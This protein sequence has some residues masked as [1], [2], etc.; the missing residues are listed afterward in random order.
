MIRHA[1]ILAFLPAVAPAAVDYT[2]Q[3]KPMLQTACVKCHGAGSQKGK[4]RV[5]TAAAAVSGGKHGAAII[6]GDSA[7]S[8]LVQA[9]DGT[10]G[11]VSKMPYKRPPLDSAQVALIRQWID[12]GAKAPADEKPSDDRHW[13]FVAPLRSTEKGAGID[14]FVR[15]RLAKEGIRP[16]PEAAPETLLRRLYLDL[17]GLPPTPEEVTAFVS[18]LKTVAASLEG[19]SGITSVY[20]RW[21]DK[22]L[23]SPHYGERWGRWWLDQ[24]RYADSNGYSIDAPRIIWPYRDWVIKALNKDLPFD[25]FT[26]EQ[27]A[28][29]LLPAATVDQKVATGFHRNTPVNGEGGIDPEQFRVESVIDRVNTTGTVWL[30]LTIGCCQCH[31][32]KFDPIPQREY[33][34]MFAFFNGTEQDGHGGTRTSTLTLPPV[35][36]EGALKL[37]IND[38]RFEFDRFFRD[39]P[40]Q[41]GD[42]EAALTPEQK[43]KLPKQ[44]IKALATPARKRTIDQQRVVFAALVKDDKKFNELESTMKKR[45]AGLSPP[46]TTLVT[47]ELPKPRETRLLIKGD[48][49]RPDAVVQRGVL[50]A[51]QPMAGVEN[52]SRL[53]LARWIVSPKNPLTARVIMNRVWQQYFGRG[54]VETENDFGTMGA[55]PTHPELL[56]WLATE[57]MAQKWSLKA[58]HR[59]IVMSQTY[60]QSSALR[61]D[62]KEKDANNYLLARQRRLRVDA[63]IVRDTCLSASGLLSS[64]VGGPPVYPPIPEGVLSLG[65]V[66]HTWPV[67]KGDDR[68]RRALYT[69]VFRATPPP[70]LSVFD[71]P[72]G[73]GSCTRRLRSNTPLQALTLLNDTS[74]HEFAEALGDRLIKDVPQ[75]DALRIERGFLLCTSRRPSAGEHDSLMALAA[76]ERRAGGDEKAVWRQVARVLLN[77]DET[78]TRE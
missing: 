72:E 32:H 21:V 14:F 57:F 40:K 6:P 19:K 30:G 2:Q 63:E 58:M 13:A 24:A 22:V 38:R 78:V 71:A 23:A 74:F 51:L 33:F 75:G 35:K 4:A 64:K 69:F 39:H 48:F 18:E 68:Y 8:L 49:T 36:D 54:I 76:A 55:A 47:Q 29:D 41:V 5:D 7:K 77:L 65:Q 20:S 1:L 70:S 66:K 52:P 11:E 15:Q 62:L 46:I 12:E 34:Q 44:V 9:I 28:G 50:S 26:I 31:D 37:D 42:A 45:E 59:A 3:I 56:D 60:R 25:Q 16:S 17:T 43:A 53:D 67:S 61:A 10:H 27:L 73:L